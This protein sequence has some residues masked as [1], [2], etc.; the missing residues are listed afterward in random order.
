MA[1]HRLAEGTGVGPGETQAVCTRI[2]VIVHAD[3]DDIKHAAPV[4]FAAAEEAQQQVALRI[5]LMSVMR[6]KPAMDA[7]TLVIDKHHRQWPGDAQMNVG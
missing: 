1:Q 7:H 3:R 5:T 2:A 6:R 4:E